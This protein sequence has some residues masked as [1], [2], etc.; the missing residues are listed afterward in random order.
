M[1]YG[2]A[3]ARLIKTKRETGNFDVLTVR[4]WLGHT[5]IKTTQNYI[6]HVDV[7]YNQAPVDWI[8]NAKKPHKG[9]K[10]K[11]DFKEK[12]NRI[13]ISALFSEFSPRDESGSA[14]I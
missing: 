5:D 7:Y 12:N 6:H 10:K 3:I 9:S 1:R 4:N 13:G 8:A 11:T 2:C 14:G